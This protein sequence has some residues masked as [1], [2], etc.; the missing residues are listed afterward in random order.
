MNVS[1]KVV[2]KTAC[3]T[4][5][6]KGLDSKGDN[7]VIYEDGGTWCF[8]CS[9]GVVDPS[10]NDN[11]I[12]ESTEEESSM[13]FG[14]KDWKALE[15]KAKTNKKDENPYSAN[16]YR[17]ISDETYEHFKVF[18][19]VFADG[20]VDKQYYP[21]TTTIEGQPEI[22]GVKIREAQQK[23]FYV[24][25]L[26]K[27]ESTHLFGQLLAEK[28]GKKTVVLTAGECFPGHVEVMTNEGFKAFE[29]LH[30]YEEILTID[31]RTGQSIMNKMKAYV[32]KKALTDLITVES[33]HISITC[34]EEHNLAYSPVKHGA[35]LF[36][37]K[38]NEPI[39]KDKAYIRVS[40][41]YVCEKPSRN[42]N[43]PT[44]R[45]ATILT[46]DSIQHR[47]YDRDSGFMY[48]STS[49][50]KYRKILEECLTDLAIIWECEETFDIE[51]RVTYHYVF[52]LPERFVEV[53]DNDYTIPLSWLL[54]MENRLRY[55][56]I[57]ILGVLKEYGNRGLTFISQEKFESKVAMDNYTY[58]A[59]LC[60]RKLNIKVKPDGRPLVLLHFENEVTVPISNDNTTKFS[61][62]GAGTMVYCVQSTSGYIMV[63]DGRHVL[64]VG[65]CDA[66][67]TY[68]ML[69]VLGAECPAVVSSTVGEKGINQYK[70]QYEFFNKF[71]KIVVIPDQDK[72]GLEALKEAVQSLPRNKVHVVELPRKDPNDMLMAGLATEFVKRYR[73][74]KPYVPDGVVGSTELYQRVLDNALIKKVPLP[75][76]LHQLEDMLVGGLPLESIVNLISSSGA[77]KTTYVNELIYYWV[78]NAPYKVGILTMELSSAQ[79]AEVLLSRHLGV[80]LSMLT[81]E[82]KYKYLQKEDV[83]QKARELFHL[84]DGSNRFYLID[85]R[86]NDPETMQKLLEQ[87]II[88]SGCQILICDPIQDVVASSDLSGQTSW[89]AWEKSIIKNYEVLMINVCHTRK[90]L[91][92][93]GPGSLGKGISE[94]DIEGSSSIYKSAK[95]NLIF[96][97]N[98]MAEDYITRNTTKL[99][100]SKN[101]DN[102]VT[103]VCGEIIYDNDSHRLYELEEYKTLHPEKF[104]TEDNE[105][106]EVGY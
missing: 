73:N 87:L 19:K 39:Q 88:S 93:G 47:A 99:E 24:N 22:C 46:Y 37:Q 71:D 62:G 13:E 77:G 49:R 9:R 44:V 30:G 57:E 59:I 10:T 12:Y 68:Q 97:R 40:T 4:C 36:K 95:I 23:K 98:K 96:T 76:F 94:E 35:S 103:G 52:H 70:T 11:Q 89:M 85:E 17:G 54:V 67:A 106:V 45:L 90:N 8:N 102:G 63:R 15:A 105:N 20:T 100:L 26:N 66:M 34:T 83:V 79:Y 42:I 48:I 5:R 101:R 41:D 29:D 78:F 18:N 56:I 69:S 21:L 92:S 65:N 82:E 1:K 33:E 58:L 6:K 3:P 104:V 61:A 91:S 25:G 31:P 27:Q 80:K 84:P 64:V 72:A 32:C 38:A 14:L 2:K 60:N 7:L 74:A 81:P 50:S 16:G 43:R 75:P 28:S 53:V 51:D 55:F 86:S